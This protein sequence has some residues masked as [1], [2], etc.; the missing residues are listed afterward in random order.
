[1]D[2]VV[3]DG[4]S[5]VKA[6]VAAKSFRY[7]SDYIGQLCRTKKIDARLVGR[8]WFVNMDSIKGHK[9]GKYKIQ[10]NNKQTTS[11]NKPSEIKLSRTPVHSVLNTKTIKVI[12]DVN[13]IN[14][15]TRS[16]KV[17]YDRDEE[18][19]IPRLIKKHVKP[20][21]T[22]RVQL[23]NSKKVKINGN[24]N[25]EV[26]FHTTELPD[27]ALSG[28]LNVT[29]IPEIVEKGIKDFSDEKTIENK[30]IS[31][32]RNIVDT[33]NLENEK[34]V[35]IKT[36]LFNTSQTSVINKNSIK[37]VS[38]KL[39][40]KN[41]VRE[42]VANKIRESKFNVVKQKNEYNLPSSFTPKIILEKPVKKTPVLILFSPL[43]ATILAVISTVVIFSAS[44]SVVVF[45][46]FYET[47]LVFQMA[48]L[49]D[50]YNAGF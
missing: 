42:D 1:M 12:K 2:S 13:F 4:V 49:L 20:P 25:N 6:S 5:Y 46:S 29:S 32:E 37:S 10:T 41:N 38:M 43:I 16:L 33:D 26:L 35:D 24:K 19:L 48:N 3:F 34:E 30:D 9:Q 17:F 23:A 15:T 14:K 50:I 18:A 45:D 40:N 44:A 22:V 31:A 21:K 7:T 8:T 39:D 36:L 47:H 11:T 28:T 27:V